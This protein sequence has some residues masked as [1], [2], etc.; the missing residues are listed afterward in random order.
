MEKIII[1]AVSKN[2]VIGLNGKI[3][4]NLSSE[5][6][7]FRNT[8]I[9]YP[10][11]MGS[12]TWESLQNPLENRLNIIVS[13]KKNVSSLSNVIFVSSI[14]KAINFCE[15]HNYKKCF[16]IGGEKIF[17]HAIKIAD[18]IIL[19]VIPK[20]YKGDKFFPKINSKWIEIDCQNYDGFVVHTYIRNKKE[21]K[22]DSKN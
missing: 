10:V 5:L 9:N 17:N 14:K 8:T 3:P 18:K 15:Q 4:W 2:F 1:A 19:S 16:I 11:I 20:N 6:K 21:I 22:I 12:N 13:R 7:H